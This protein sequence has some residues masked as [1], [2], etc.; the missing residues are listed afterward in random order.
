MSAPSMRT[1][2]PGSFLSDPGAAKIARLR[3]RF[4][5]CRQ[6]C[7]GACLSEVTFTE[8]VTVCAH[9]VL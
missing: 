2:L 3:S 4:L 5:F 8:K 1:A 7:K 6:S 9:E